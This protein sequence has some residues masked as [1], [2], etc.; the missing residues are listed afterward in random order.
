MGSPAPAPISFRTLHHTANK[1]NEEFKDKN[2]VL[3]A[4]TKGRKIHILD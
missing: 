3:I 1:E 4:M 2:H